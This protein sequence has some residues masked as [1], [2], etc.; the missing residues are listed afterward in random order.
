MSEI[1]LCIYLV[2]ASFSALKQPETVVP[3]LQVPACAGL[4]WK[5]KRCSK[6]IVAP[7]GKISLVVSHCGISQGEVLLASPCFSPAGLGTSILAMA[8][9]ITAPLLFALQGQG[10]QC[11]GLWWQCQCPWDKSQLTAG[12]AAQAV[13]LSHKWSQGTA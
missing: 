13:L 11:P 5:R 10:S 4:R 1:C 6:E 12:S 8:S 7:R 3:E 2:F 9:L